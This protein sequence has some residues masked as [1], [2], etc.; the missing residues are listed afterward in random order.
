MW[1]AKPISIEDLING[2][3][4]N[5]LS[6]DQYFRVLIQC[7]YY[8]TWPKTVSENIGKGQIY[9]TEWDASHYKKVSGWVESAYISG[10]L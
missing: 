1:E 5:H 9:F 7:E 3:E 4:G 6:V 10:L 8:Q 2:I